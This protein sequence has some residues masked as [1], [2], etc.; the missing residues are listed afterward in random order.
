MI[1]KISMHMLLGENVKDLIF[2]SCMHDNLKLTNHK[3]NLHRV[4]CRVLKP[5]LK[6]C[7]CMIKRE[8]Q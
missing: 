1:S 5:G 2:T 4:T 3:M 6:E 8:Y 7:T